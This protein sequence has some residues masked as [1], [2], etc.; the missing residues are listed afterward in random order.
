MVKTNI[1]NETVFTNTKTNYNFRAQ[2]L[3]LGM[4][5]AQHGLN[6]AE[7]KMYVS[8]SK[9]WKSCRENTALYFD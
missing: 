3:Y 2:C 1:F 4:R 5:Q 6:T 9:H 8:K 7:I